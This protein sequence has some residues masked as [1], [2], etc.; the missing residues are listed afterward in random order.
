MQ[1][2]SITKVFEV[3]RVFPSVLRSSMVT[4][5]PLTKSD[6]DDK[7]QETCNPECCNLD[8]PLRS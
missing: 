7:D 2:S 1:P 3:P 5:R 8:L 4:D 6:D